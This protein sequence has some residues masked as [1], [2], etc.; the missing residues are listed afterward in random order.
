MKLSFD[1]K[2]VE[3]L[4]QKLQSIAKQVPFATSK[5]INATAIKVQ[6]HEVNT[7]LPASLKLRG[8]WYKP[9]TRFGINIQFSNKRNLVAVVGSRANWLALVESGGKKHPTKTALAIPTSNID[10]SRPRRKADKPGALLQRK[11]A[12]IATMKSGKAG[13]FIRT[14]KERLPIKALYLFSGAVDVPDI[15]NFFEEGKAV[16]DKTYTQTFSQELTKAI[17]SAK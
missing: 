16:V 2:G 4:Q 7:V 14:G 8:Q 11:G 15:L 5:A 10:T 3:P 13:I 9:R 17:Q 1:I 12:F 6:A